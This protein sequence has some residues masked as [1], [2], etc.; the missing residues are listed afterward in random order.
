M[1]E[2]VWEVGKYFSVLICVWI[3]I[4]SPP[5]PTRGGRDWS[6]L[7]CLTIRADILLARVIVA[8]ALSRRLNWRA[9]WEMVSAKAF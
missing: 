6:G 8:L 7:T 5:E 4:Q 9:R 3:I 2:K 1:R